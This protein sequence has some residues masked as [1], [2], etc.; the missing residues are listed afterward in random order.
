MMSAR[1]RP[2]LDFRVLTVVRQLVT[3]EVARR[4]LTMV[5]MSAGWGAAIQS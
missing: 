2:L 5:W 3:S 4:V 1:A